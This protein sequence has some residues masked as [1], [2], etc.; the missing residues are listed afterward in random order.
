VYEFHG[1]IRLA[2]TSTEID[3]GMLDEKVGS[4]NRFISTIEW[5]SGRAEVIL[6]NGLY[7]LVVNAAPNR[8]RDEALDLLK[9][10]EFVNENFSGA[11]GI[12]YE[13]DEQSRTAYG[14]GVFSVRI[15]RRG[16][17]EV[18]LDPFLSPFVPVVEDP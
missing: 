14:R 2:E 9:I 1:W 12:I 6:L 5:S 7:T 16:K 8:R 18:A 3:E 13:Y 4:L 10:V 15:I 11:Y 17:C